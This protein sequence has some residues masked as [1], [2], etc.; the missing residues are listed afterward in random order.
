MSARLTLGGVGGSC[1]RQ[2]SVTNSHDV[3]TPG[4]QTADSDTTAC[5]PRPNHTDINHIRLAHH[6]NVR[7]PRGIPPPP[8]P[9]HWGIPPRDDR[10]VTATS[11]DGDDACD[12]NPLR[13]L[14]N[15]NTFRPMTMSERRYK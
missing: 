10:Q 1:Q 6:S 5:L 12:T 8:P 11:D 15:V 4:P 14:R 2:P 13:R 9:T 3:L 7:L